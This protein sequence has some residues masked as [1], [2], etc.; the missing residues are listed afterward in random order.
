MHGLIIDA[1]V[2]VDLYG[3]AAVGLDDQ[4]VQVGADP[5]GADDEHAVGVVA[6][7]VVAVVAADHVHVEL[8]LD[9]V[10]R[11]DRKV[12]HVERAV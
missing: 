3:H 11:H 4:I 10:E 7:D 2:V 9:L 12:G 6:L 1:R 8:R 5:I